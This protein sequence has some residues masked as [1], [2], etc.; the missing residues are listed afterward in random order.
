MDNR[1]YF[2]LSGFLSLTLFF[3]FA[4]LFI[5]I[6]FNNVK[7][8]SFGL[9]KK[10]YI[11]V[12]IEL[13][14]QKSHK[15][16]QVKKNK[17]APLS[18]P[19]TDT[20]IKNIDVNDLFSDVWTQKIDLKKPKRKIN[21][22]R[23]AELEKKIQKTKENNITKISEKLSTLENEENSDLSADAAA[24]EVNEY[25]AKIQSLVYHYFN[26]PQNTAGNSVKAVIELDPLGKVEDFRILEYS[27]NEALNEE[28]DKIKLRIKNVIF[29]RNP[30][31]V[32]SR[33]T[34]ILKSKE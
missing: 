6:L 29:P 25:L 3:S 7:I 5:Y 22:K 21:S 12:S 18:I 14:K 24:E 15:K 8:K 34:V 26:V 32:S 23:I 2:Y 16:S 10:N 19:Q 4:L 9:K 30:K 1:K 28:A 33:R 31:H 20:K 17:S 11:S 13:P 27:N